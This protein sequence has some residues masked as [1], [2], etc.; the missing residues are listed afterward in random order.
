MLRFNSYGNPR[1][2]K[3]YCTRL[4][5]YFA[6]LRTRGIT[7]SPDQLVTDD[8]TSI[9]YSAPEDVYTRASNLCRLHG[10]AIENGT[11]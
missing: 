8:L 7:M 1:T 4:V 5:S 3:A 11:H 6:W 2:E 9:Y 10:G